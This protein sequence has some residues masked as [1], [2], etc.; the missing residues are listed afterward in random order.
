[1]IVGVCVSLVKTGQE[2]T[3][4]SYHLKKRG[5]VLTIEDVEGVD[6]ASGGEVPWPPFCTYET[7]YFAGEGELMDKEIDEKAFA[8][9]DG[10]EG[11][12]TYV[13]HGGRV[14]DVSDSPLWA[15]GIHMG[16]HA[17]GKDLT[18]DIEAAPHGTEV[19]DRYPQVGRIARRAGIDT[20]LPQTLSKFLALHPFFRRHPH[21]ATVHF[22]IVLTLCTSFF[23][24]LYVVTGKG[25][26]DQSAWYC[27]IGALLFTPVAIVTGLFTWWVNYTARSMLPITVKQ[28]LSVFVFAALLVL[29]V[30]RLVLPDPPVGF[31]IG[32]IL[33]FALALAVGPAVLVVSY[34]GG[35]LTFPLE[36]E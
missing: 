9:N 30:W 36:K 1:M 28:I 2:S 17:A 11:R 3:T 25:S 29:F 12:R 8:S 10:K 19:L 13:S 23:S 22:P 27:L 16:R 35:R 20:H 24:I 33:Y 4:V 32:T 7:G 5:R 34:Y 18:A 26:F 6:D 15:G 31:S 14:I 21:P